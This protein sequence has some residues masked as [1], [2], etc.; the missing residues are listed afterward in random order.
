MIIQFWSPVRT[1]VPFIW[2]ANTVVY[3]FRLFTKFLEYL[4]HKQLL[5]SIALLL[6]RS[7]NGLYAGRGNGL[8]I[9]LDL[10]EGT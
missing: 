4:N 1:A 3:M 5:E 2:K 8:F 10:V 6:T 7:A 9:V